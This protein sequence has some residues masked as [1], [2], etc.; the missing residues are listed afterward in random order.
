MADL[1]LESLGNGDGNNYLLRDNTKI[2]LSGS[3][4]ISGDLIPATD[5]TYNL[6][7]N[8]RNYSSVYAY[9]FPSFMRAMSPSDTTDIFLIAGT[10]I[11]YGAYL[12]L[13]SKDTTSGSVA[14]SF[15]L[16]ARDSNNQAELIGTPDGT[17]TWLGTNIIK[18]TTNSMLEIFGGPGWKNGAQLSLRGINTAES[19]NFVLFA[20]DGTDNYKMLGGYPNGT[21]T[22][23]GQSIQTTSDQRFKQQISKIDNDLLDAWEDVELS[24][25]KYNDAVEEKGNTARLHTGYVVQQIDDACKKHN[26]DVSKYGLYCHEEYSEET[27]EV[28]NEDGTKETK[29][30]RPANEHYSLRY[31][32]ALVV[33]CAYLRMKNKELQAQLDNLFNIVGKLTEKVGKLEG[34]LQ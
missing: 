34:K 12:Q 33:E 27:R 20:H 22:W 16:T 9:N 24:Q 3:N 21:L 1:E 26:V 30:I 11:F 25:F 4:Q 8:N 10:D 2:P 14:G 18:P 19:G 15:R 17:L 23:N 31:T 5:N 29:V 28:E 6:G 32:E 13:S 7:S